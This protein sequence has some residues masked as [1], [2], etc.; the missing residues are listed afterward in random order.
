METPPP[1]TS[2]PSPVFNDEVALEP[3][4]VPPTTAEF[5]A[6]AT[7]TADSMVPGGPAVLG[8]RET[9]KDPGPHPA[10]GHS[11]T[12]PGVGVECSL[13]EEGQV[14]IFSSVVVPVVVVV[15]LKEEEAPPV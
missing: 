1:L 9:V 7:A 15:V 10:W 4:T 14:R 8:G 11:A 13:L 2:R 12:T 3:A 6:A 5:N